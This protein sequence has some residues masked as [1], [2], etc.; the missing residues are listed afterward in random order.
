MGFSRITENIGS[1]DSQVRVDISKNK[2]IC[3]L[4]WNVFVSSRQ[5]LF[6]GV[7]IGTHFPT[8]FTPLDRDLCSGQSASYW[9][10]ASRLYEVGLLRTGQRVQDRDSSTNLR[11]GMELI[12]S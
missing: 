6:S 5:S 4:F 11:V 12:G 2:A 8:M 9:C 1:L 3:H 7:G 10:Q